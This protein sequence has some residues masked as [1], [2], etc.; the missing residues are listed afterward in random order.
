MAFTAFNSTEIQAGKPT[1]QE[2]FTKLK[3][4]FD[5]HESR[6]LNTEASL[7]NFRPIAFDA[8]G[9]YWRFG[10]PQTEVL[11]ER[12]N[13]DI[14]LTAARLWVIEAGTSG[15]LEVDVF[16]YRGADPAISIFSTPPSVGF[17]AGNRALSTNAVF[18]VTNL[19]AGDFLELRINSVQ[20]SSKTF[21][22]FLEFEKT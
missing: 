2:L 9:E 5:D 7:A 17:A 8:L 18:S 16:L 3:D 14:T 19:L 10:S 21:H 4:N 6:L 12:I 11:W 13:F 22:L 15:T 1:K 20:T